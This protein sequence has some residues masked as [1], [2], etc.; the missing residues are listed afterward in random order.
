MNDAC[1]YE[2]DVLRAVEEDRWTAEL[3]AHV[4]TATPEDRLDGYAA[5]DRH[6]CATTNPCAPKAQR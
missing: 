5:G 6:V 4:S 1:R 2:R 3:R